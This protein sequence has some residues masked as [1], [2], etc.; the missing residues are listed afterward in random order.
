MKREI[1]AKIAVLAVCIMSISLVASAGS[2]AEDCKAKAAAAIQKARE[3]REASK[4]TREEF[5]NKLKQKAASLKAGDAIKLSGNVWGAGNSSLMVSANNQMYNLV[6]DKDVAVM[7]KG[8]KR[9]YNE[10]Y[11]YKL[12]SG[13]RKFKIDIEYVVLGEDKICT[14]IDVPKS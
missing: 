8:E 6:V 12:S 10:F 13:P 1:V 11:T 9:T 5:N 4:R 14:K 7:I 2:D 3:E